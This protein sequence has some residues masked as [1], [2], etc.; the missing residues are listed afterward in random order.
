MRIYPLGRD[1]RPWRRFWKG[2]WAVLVLSWLAVVPA[3]AYW[4][5]EMHDD[6]R[7]VE[8]R[9]YNDDF[10]LQASSSDYIED[11]YDGEFRWFATEV[12]KIGSLKCDYVVVQHM[13]LAGPLEIAATYSDRDG[14]AG[15]LFSSGGTGYMHFASRFL[16]DK[17]TNYYWS[18]SAIY[19]EAMDT[20]DAAV[21]TDNI[22]WEYGGDPYEAP[23]PPVYTLLEVKKRFDVN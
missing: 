17:G 1:C 19:V 7:I 14:G 6:S 10:E 8:M 4:Y 13:S 16:Y 5:I 21:Y 11:M 15:W 2:F 18:K 12:W 9:D 3:G 20:G 23:Q 22:V